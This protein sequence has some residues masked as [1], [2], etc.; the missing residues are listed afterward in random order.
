MAE[1]R[2]LIGILS[3]ADLRIK[4]TDAERRTVFEAFLFEYCRLRK[5]AGA[6]SRAS[7]RPWRPGG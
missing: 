7:G 4:S 1:I 5:K 2:G 6:T 3:D